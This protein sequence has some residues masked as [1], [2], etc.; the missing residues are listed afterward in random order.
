[1]TFPALLF[2]AA[3]SLTVGTAA[4]DDTAQPDYEAEAERAMEAFDATGMVAAVTLDGE[5]VYEGA[6]GKA[7]EATDTPM[8]TD[9]LV[10]FASIG[11]AFT[12][13]SLAILVDR[14][15]V[16][17]DE[18]IRTYI[19]EFKMHDPWV[20]EH[21]TVRDAL[22]HRSGLPLGAG[23]LLFWPDAESEVD[24]IIAALPHLRPSTEFR[25]A[26]AYDNLLYMVAG[27]VVARTSGKSWAD[28]VTEE[29]LE[30]VGLENC[31]ADR[32]RMKPGQVLATGH[33]RAPSD[34]E[35]TPVSETM[36]FKPQHSALGGLVC[37]AED[38]M[39]WARF[40]LDG[41][42]TK[43]GTRLVSEEQ[44]KELW[45]GVT[46]KGVG[47]YLRESGASH[48]QLYALG[49][50]VT[51][52]EGTLMVSHSGG[53]P[54][55]ISHFILLPEKDIGIFA[56]AN[57]YRRTAIA[58]TFQLADDLVGGR[59]F[60]YIAAYGGDFAKTLTQSQ[61]AL[62]DAVSPPADAEAPS[63]PLAAYT[64][65]YRDEWYGDVTVRL[66]EGQ[67]F[68]DMSRSEILDGPLTHYAKDRFV[69]FWPDRSLK[70]DAFVTFTEENGHITRMKMKAVSDI[71]DFS[72]DFHDLDLVRVETEE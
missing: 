14:G 31:A 13:T 46:P 17:W 51:D 50:N 4:A 34:E 59:D 33:E 30:P 44:V 72:Y 12:T 65:V 70:A 25:S 19:P 69:A 16:D 10:P 24:D 29:I 32:T 64:G 5:T 48:L 11:K 1:M 55:V 35:G 45:K 49:W 42:V 52:F 20:T 23:D 61:K 58:Y 2:S 6:F 40:W 7:N 57:D 28:F 62:S 9:M 15:L 66:E 36:L 43:D 68:L 47:K 8:T 38:L 27:E 3:L 67:L 63:L 41:A 26:Y 21:F 53:A 37:P 60:D 39:I 56:S 71:T 18:P 54:G 22:T